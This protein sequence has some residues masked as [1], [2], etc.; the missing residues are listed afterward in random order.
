MGGHDTMVG[1][2]GGLAVEEAI[3]LQS[4]LAPHV[5]LHP[6]PE[7][8]SLLG[9]AWVE[10]LSPER[11]SLA[12]ACG[13]LWEWPALK[14]VHATCVGVEVDF[15]YIS[16]L[17]AFRAGAPLLAAIRLLPSR[18]DVLLLNAQGIAHIRR[19]GMACHLGL[20]TGIPTVGCT[21]Q[22]PPFPCPEP[23]IT[24]GSIRL[25]QD[26]QTTLGAVVRVCDG[27]RPL[28]VSPGHLADVESSIRLV[29]NCCRGHRLPEPLRQTR[30]FARAEMHRRK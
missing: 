5:S 4:S 26:G 6:L 23:E 25:I 3:A 13:M 9:S 15:P 8:F 11:N 17:F 27:V 22:R 2:P 12:V 14:I 10:F 18:P 28:F 24:R 16:G 1:I 29:L 30:A 19:F 7:D 20:L 21:R